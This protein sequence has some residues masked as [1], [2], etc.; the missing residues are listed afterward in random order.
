MSSGIW[1]RATERGPKGPEARLEV[2]PCC[3]IVPKHQEEGKRSGEGAD[4]EE[5]TSKGD[6]VC[7]QEKE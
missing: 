1:L 3:E 6:H 2:S 4:K 5:I 7:E